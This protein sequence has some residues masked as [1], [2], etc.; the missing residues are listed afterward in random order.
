MENE[1]SGQLLILEMVKKTFLL[2][3]VKKIFS[4]YKK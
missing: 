4:Q 3:M 2:F 1:W